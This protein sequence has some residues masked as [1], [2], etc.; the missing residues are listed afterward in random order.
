MNLEGR[1][2]VT[3]RNSAQGATID[4]GNA[5]N[6]ISNMLNVSQLA[7]SGISNL[8]DLKKT[9]RI[10]TIKN[11]AFTWKYESLDFDTLRTKI[12]ERR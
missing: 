5:P 6:K 11:T 2:T 3:R 12:F 8:Y 7:D 10:N 4:R 1:K 9:I